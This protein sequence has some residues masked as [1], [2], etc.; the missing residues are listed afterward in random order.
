M[1]KRVIIKT[2]LGIAGIVSVIALTGCLTLNKAPIIKPVESPIKAK[3]GLLFSTIFNVYDDHS[4][5]DELVI[6][7]EILGFKDV[8][9]EKI[10]Y[11]QA[12]YLS[13]SLVLLEVGRV[14]QIANL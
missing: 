10:P 13:S 8:K 2:I 3:E 12:I 1:G 14:L 7:A 9:I 4:T 6:E 11:N 5:L